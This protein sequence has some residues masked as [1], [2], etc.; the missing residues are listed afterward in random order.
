[1]T[2]K[3]KIGNKICNFKIQ[4]I[5]SRAK[6]GQNNIQKAAT[7]AIVFTPC[8]TLC[9]F[10]LF[11]SSAP[12]SG[13]ADFLKLCPDS[14]SVLLNINEC[15]GIRDGVERIRSGRWQNLTLKLVAHHCGPET[16]H[17]LAVRFWGCKTMC[18][19]KCFRAKCST[20]Y[21]FKTLCG[22]LK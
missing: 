16:Q 12:E 7:N 9:F 5:K 15:H 11:F 21:H 14:E 13:G 4:K 22:S 19:V 17:L 3:T 20:K 2:C 10:C 8:Q 1:M 18:N 6:K